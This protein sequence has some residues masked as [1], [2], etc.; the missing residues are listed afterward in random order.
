MER[1][2]RF[3]RAC[4]S[5]PSSSG[6]DEDGPPVDGLVNG[7]PASSAVVMSALAIA[8]WVMSGL[9]QFLVDTS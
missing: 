1:G 7:I 9:R 3:S 4:I 2:R 8:I 5:F 6:F